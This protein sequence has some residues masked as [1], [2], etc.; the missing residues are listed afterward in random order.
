MVACLLTMHKPAI[1]VNRE[2]ATSVTR[3]KGTVEMTPGSTPTVEPNS[4]IHPTLYVFEEEDILLNDSGA[5]QSAPRY[6]ASFE[7]NLGLGAVYEHQDEQGNKAHL[8]TYNECVL[9][10]CD[11]F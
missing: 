1:H 10:P 4:I 2:W 5:P 3:S 8:E 11:S 6:C 9:Y 7:G